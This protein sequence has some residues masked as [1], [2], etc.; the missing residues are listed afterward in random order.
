MVVAGLI[1]VA[2]VALCLLYPLGLI[3]R[4]GILLAG[5]ALA[6]LIARSALDPSM[7]RPVRL[8][9]VT[10]T[11]EVTATVR[12]NGA[13]RSGSSLQ[14][15]IISRNWLPTNQRLPATTRMQGEA[16]AV[17]ITDDRYLLVTLAVAPGGRSYEE[18]IASPCSNI[19]LYDGAERP[20][21]DAIL[22]NA[23]G[24][25]GPCDIPLDRVPGM[26]AV[27]RSLEPVGF[28]VVTP[29]TMSDVFGVPVEFVSLTFGRADE[30]LR[31]R[32]AETFPWLKTALGRTVNMPIELAPNPHLSAF[33]ISYISTGSGE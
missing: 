13:L 23:A 17:P 9:E 10:L 15:G 14:S 16:V 2:A 8:N 29:A 22:E 5:V 26:M 19:F 7:T 1:I 30:P 6:F 33:Y 4:L 18:V 27:T 21:V 24:F 3:S 32:L 25:T 28:E 12:V 11:Y 20:T 31:F